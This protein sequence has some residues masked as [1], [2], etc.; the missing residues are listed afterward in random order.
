MR[1]AVVGLGRMGRAI[2]AV[3]EQRGH[4]VV[5]AIGRED[6]PGG[7]ALTRERL[8][9]AEVVFEFTRPDAAPPNLERLAVLGARVVTGTTGWQPEL[10]RVTRMFEGGGGL[11]HATNFSIGMLL[12]RHAARTLARLL[13]RFPDYDAVLHE[14]HH[15][16]KLDAPSGS[17]LTLQADLRAADPDRPYPIT[18]TRVGSAPGTHELLVDGPRET[19]ALVHTVRDRA[20][21]AEG[22]VAAGEWL[23][24]RTGVFTFD[25][26][27]TGGPA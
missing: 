14:T 3:A 23:R 11:L 26:V 6:N 2:L 9:A 12:T 8:G 1:I 19:V 10:P 5:A 21:F 4:E 16:R 15:A 17:A 20:V 22:A 7:T 27:I 24:G 18:A 13:R 25:D